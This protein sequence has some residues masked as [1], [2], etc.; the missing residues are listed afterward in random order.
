MP[1]STSDGMG[2]V[3][4]GDVAAVEHKLRTTEA[5]LCGVL[6]ALRDAGLMPAIMRAFDEQQQGVNRQ[7][8]ARWLEQHLG[9]DTNRP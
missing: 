6:K 9:R 5:I 8:V 2:Q 4:Y 3:N 1:C 7:D